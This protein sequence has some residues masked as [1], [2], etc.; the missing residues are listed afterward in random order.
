MKI[1][2]SSTLSV[3]TVYLLA[4]F[5]KVT[6]GSFVESMLIFLVVNQ[7]MCYTLKK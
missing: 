4:V 7:I 1:I 2:F 5:S 3:L 6:S